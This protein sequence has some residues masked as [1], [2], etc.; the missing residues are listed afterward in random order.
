M[1][2]SLLHLVFEVPKGRKSRKVRIPVLI[3]KGSTKYKIA[4]LIGL[5]A[6]DGGKRHGNRAG[7]S[8]ASRLLRDD[9]SLLLKELKIKH[10]LDE[11]LYKKYKRRYFGLYFTKKSIAPLMQGCRSGQTD[12]ILDSFLKKIG[13]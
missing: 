11:W 7:L 10:Y 3:R 12:R 1:I 8:T 13:G 4:F 6:T 2:Y 9:I 5:F